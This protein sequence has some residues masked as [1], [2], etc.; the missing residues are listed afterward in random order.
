MP[1]LAD[2]SL[3]HVGPSG[4]Y[5]VPES[6]PKSIHYFDISTRKTRR[7]FNIEK[8]SVNGLSVSPDGRWTLYI[9]G[10]EHTGDLMP[11]ENFK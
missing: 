7:L 11:L 2:R 10:R 9:Q 6:V 8:A 4:I 5:F 1:A 3:Y